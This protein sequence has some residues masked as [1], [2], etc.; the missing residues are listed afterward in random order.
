MPWLG[1]NPPFQNPRSCGPGNL[2]LFGRIKLSSIR[3]VS[4]HEFEIYWA[5]SLNKSLCS[6]RSGHKGGS[7]TRPVDDSYLT[8]VAPITGATRTLSLCLFV[9]SLFLGRARLLVRLS[10]RSRRRRSESFAFRLQSSFPSLRSCCRD[11]VSL[12]AALFGFRLSG[13]H[14]GLYA[15]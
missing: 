14:P 11:L 12:V 7:Y 6:R 10:S 9:L 13:S 15:G 5:K 3:L 1:W 2:I 4:A 8:L